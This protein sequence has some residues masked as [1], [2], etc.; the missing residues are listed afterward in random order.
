[1]Q[2]ATTLQ[3]VPRRAKPKGIK[4]ECGET[5]PKQGFETAAAPATV[6]GEHPRT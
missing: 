2:E 1:M 3:S 5:G 4:W 6:S